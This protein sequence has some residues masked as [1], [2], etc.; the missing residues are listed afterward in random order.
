VPVPRCVSRHPEAQPRC[1]LRVTFLAH[2]PE[3]AELVRPVIL[4][5]SIVLSPSFIVLPPLSAT[6]VVGRDRSLPVAVDRCPSGP[7]TVCHHCNRS[8]SVE[9][10]RSVVAGCCLS[11]PVIVSRPVIVCRRPLLQCASRCLSVAIVVYRPISLFPPVVFRLPVRFVVPGTGCLLPIIVC[12]DHFLCRDRS[13]S[14][15]TGRGVPGCCLSHRSFSRDSG[16]VVY[17]R[18][19]VVCWS[20]SD[21]CTG[22]S[23]SPPAF[24][25]V[26]TGY[27]S[28]VAVSCDRW[29]PVSRC[30]CLW[31]P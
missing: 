26:A 30:S 9:I 6:V 27:S 16:P 20:L 23:L 19:V 11:P 22:R 28:P 15:G 2:R 13:L 1:A 18:P 10:G 3:G 4:S 14:A 8:L 29:V 12:S 21:W 25:S 7:V 31:H 5:P 17:L 24:M